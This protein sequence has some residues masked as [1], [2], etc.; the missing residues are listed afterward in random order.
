MTRE[1]VTC[2]CI[3]VVLDGPVCVTEK[4]DKEKEKESVRILTN[5]VINLIF[6]ILHDWG[7]LNLF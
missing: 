4:E 1:C 2:A 6:S 5:R 3:P 7:K